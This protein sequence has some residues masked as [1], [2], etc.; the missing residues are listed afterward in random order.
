MKFIVPREPFAQ[1]VKTVS[2]TADPQGQVVGTQGVVIQAQDNGTL[3]VRSTNLMVQTTTTTLADV[4]VPGSAVIPAQILAELV[5]RL[6]SDTVTVEATPK[7]VLM[8]SGASRTTLRTMETEP[9][10]LQGTPTAH[11][12][13]WATEGA[14]WADIARRHLDMAATDNLRPVLQGVL[15]HF[16]ENHLSVVTTDG[17]RLALSHFVLPASGGDAKAPDEREQAF[18]V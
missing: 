9:P 5:Q 12:I 3:T 1:A 15:F 14:T 10:V 13:T 6:P 11:P 7:G 18:V 8:K 2:R 4:T 16:Q 17:T